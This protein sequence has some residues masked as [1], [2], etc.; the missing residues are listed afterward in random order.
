MTIQDQVTSHYVSPESSVIAKAILEAVLVPLIT[1]DIRGQ[2]L[3]FNVA[4]QNLFGYRSDEIVGHTIHKLIPE[5]YPAEHETFL[6]EYG[7]AESCGVVINEREVMGRRKDG[8]IFPVQLSVSAIKTEGEPLLIGVLFDLG[9]Q[10]NIE[11]ELRIAAAAFETQEAIMVTDAGGNIVLVNKAFEKITGYSPEEV[12]GRNPRILSSG[13][14]DSAFYAQM[15]QSI[16]DTGNWRGQIWDRAKSGKLYPKEVT[17]TAVK[18]V[19]GKT[20][21]YVAFF[22]DISLRKKSEEEINALA[23]YDTL[24]RLPNRRLLVDRLENALASSALSQQY[25]ALLV[26]DLDKFKALNDTRGLEV[27]DT[28]LV[29][30]ARRLKFYAGKINTVARLGGDEFVILLETIAADEVSSIQF[31]EKF[32]EKIR[33]VLAAPYLLKQIT[34]YSSSSIGVCL[35][36]GKADSVNELI[37]R[38]DMAMYQAKDSGRN[39]VCFFN[40]QLQQS[41]ESRAVLEADMRIAITH[42]QFQLYYQIQVNQGQLPIGAE[43]LIRWNHPKRGMVSPAQFIPIAEESMLIIEI[44]LWV[45]E[46]ACQQLAIWK[47]C[48]QARHLSLSVNVSAAQFKQDNFVEVVEAFIK[49]YR[50]EPSRLKLEL[51]ESIAL[52]DLD[53]VIAKMMALRY[54]VGVKLS[55]DDFGTGFSC[56]SYLKRLPLDQL[57]IDQSFVRELKDKSSDAVL[58]KSIIDMALNFGLDVI[59]EGVE[60]EI[61]AAL[62]KTNGCNS[63]QGYLYGKPLPLEQFEALLSVSEPY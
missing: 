50:I 40:P 38:A 56:L 29:E 16:I 22:T 8:T 7:K 35:F 30:V 45:L 11:N 36:K 47:D 59:A 42:Q 13:R 20:I 51:T 14:H 28:L 39:C 3:S 32:A 31:V 55:L 43:A 33:S 60:T 4:A 10:K 9:K 5:A 27:G 62:L 18:G 24:T 17:I 23:Y 63:Y 19:D 2:L 57:K 1:I 25:G 15:W 61:Q 46:T 26:I 34:Q 52:D 54:V 41:V 6:A 21:H 12:I 37:K 49:K 58:V 48:T 44:G 53:I